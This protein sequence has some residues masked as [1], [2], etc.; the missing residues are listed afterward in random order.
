LSLATVMPAGDPLL[1]DAVIGP[2]FDRGYYQSVTV[3]SV[4]GEVLAKRELPAKPP[5]VPDWFAALAP[6]Q[7]PSNESLI[8][9]GWQ[10]MGRVVVTSHPNFAYN[11]LWSTA[12]E[13]FVLLLMIYVIALV[14]VHLFLRG[15]LRPLEAIRRVAHS[16][17]EKHFVTV[18]QMPSAPELRDVVVAINGMSGKLKKVIETEIA[19][20]ER[21]RREA[22]HDQV[23]GLE[24]RRGLELQLNAL[25][26][27]RNDVFSIAIL[28][29]AIDGFKEFNQQYGFQQGDDLLRTVAGALPEMLEGTQ[30]V[31]A[32]LNGATFAIGVANVARESIDQLA[33]DVC[34]AVGMALNEQGQGLRFNLGAVFS[35]EMAPLGSLLAQ[36]DMALGS[37]HAR[38]P[39]EYEVILA[40]ES[41]QGAQGAQKWRDEILL[42]LDN[43]RIALHAQAVIQLGTQAVI[44]REIVGRLL[45]SD[46]EFISAA[47]FLPM[48]ARHNLL[49]QLDSHL[50][51][52]VVERMKND[53][54]IAGEVAVN[55]AG[56]SVEDQGF[57]R[58]VE[59]LLINNHAI[60]GRLVF[61][62][63]EFGVVHNLTATREF[64][65]ILRRHGARFAV[66]NFGLHRD[67]FGYLQDIVPDYI[68][69]SAGLTRD[70]AT[71]KQAEFFVSSVVRI[72]QPLD[73]PI[74]AQAVEH[75]NVL[76]VLE[77]LGVFGYQG[78]L[79]GRPEPFG[80]ELRTEGSV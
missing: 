76:P 8:T 51:C 11:Q 43:D 62:M 6:L 45:G 32:R 66:D 26:Q 68:K 21:L 52:R 19:D 7:A 46:G 40:G 48:A 63:A 36:A 33:K 41:D 69:L 58:V 44:Q 25:L 73:I 2:A 18:Q 74:I 54:A 1:I 9:S 56:R 67:A 30:L 71:D 80:E 13:T 15:V 22:N 50:L 35:Q 64:V 12:R 16:I 5:E 31:H 75:E 72:A 47:R 3:I 34:N 17:S 27:A 14:V 59:E 39:Q 42:A 60:A 29:L 57:V 55:I 37:A 10:Q 24:N 38:G 4:R 53:S 20:A 77:R 49:P 28:L 79:C 65:K 78:Y 61:E 23:T 70:L